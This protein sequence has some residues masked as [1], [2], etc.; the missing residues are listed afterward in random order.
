MTQWFRSW[1]GAPTDHKWRLIAKRAKTPTSLVVSFAWALLDRA[2]QSED[3]GCF[4]GAD[5][6]AFADFLD[7]DEDDLNR[8]LA[9]FDEKGVT[10]EGR[11][12]AWEKRQP[13]KEDPTATERSRIHRAKQNQALK[14]DATL[15]NAMQRPATPDKI[16][17]EQNRED[18]KDIFSSETSSDPTPKKKSRNSY[19]EAFEAFWRAYPTDQLM[20]KANAAKQFARLSDED[21]AKATAAI[22]AFIAYCQKIP[23]YRPVHA[24]RFLSQRRFDGFL[25]NTPPPSRDPAEQRREFQ[26]GLYKFAIENGT[27]TPMAPAIIEKARAMGLEI[28]GPVL[29]FSA[30]HYADEGMAQ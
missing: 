2:S 21:Q 6:E 29:E 15:C 22:P 24:E 8:I 30:Q 4:E 16:R 23:D 3:R 12:L 27:K 19:S 26:L 20:S 13:K 28:P 11:F 14:P 7:C 17:E 5:L 25:D 1:H 18:K 10:A 9:Q